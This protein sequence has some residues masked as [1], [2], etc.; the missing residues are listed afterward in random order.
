MTAL[1]SL[2]VQNISPI[3]FH[4]KKLL[5]NILY[6]TIWL[7]KYKKLCKVLDTRKNQ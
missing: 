2:W 7:I 1:T 5:K 4:G 3:S 6:P